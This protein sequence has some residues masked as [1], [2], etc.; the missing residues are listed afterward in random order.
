M[1]V[2]KKRIVDKSIIIMLGVWLLLIIV[3]YHLKPIIDNDLSR[4]YTWSLEYAQHDYISFIKHTE[5]E[6]KLSN[7][8]LWLVGRTGKIGL[9][10]AVTVAIV[11]GIAFWIIYDAKKVFH[12]SQKY[13][14]IYWAFVFLL[15][16][17]TAIASNVRNVIAFSI[18]S[19]A[20]YFDF[21]KKRKKIIVIP[22]Y[23]IPCSI[24]ISSLLF[25]VLRLAI[26][27][28]KKLRSLGLFIALM[29]PLFIKLLY[30]NINHIKL[31]SLGKRF[32]QK[33]YN[34]YFNFGNKEWV[35][36]VSASGYEQS[37]KLIFFLLFLVLLLITY[38]TFNLVKRKHMP[39]INLL[40]YMEMVLLVSIM[41]MYIVVPTYFRFSIVVLILFSIPFFIMHEIG[42]PKRG[43]M[44]LFYAGYLNLIM[45]GLISQIYQFYFDFRLQ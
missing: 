38:Y 7:S 30:Q 32:I 1:N 4:Y 45:Y 25:I 5:L 12:I 22:L 10:P 27:I 29:L 28:Y 42:F 40:A 44:V 43:I 37:R 20:V 2:V 19:L 34:Y 26:P 23:I 35:D 16:P 36:K 18:I 21:V 15:F 9:I 3:A 11:Y 31:F 24:H 33:A 17:Y 14:Y 6:S 13:F 41:T 39:Y 8:F